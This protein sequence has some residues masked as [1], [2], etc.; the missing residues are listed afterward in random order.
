MGQPGFGKSVTEGNLFE[1]FADAGEGVLLIDVKGDLAEQ[2]VRR[3]KHID[4]VVYVAP[5]AAAEHEH[6][7]S[8]NPLDFDR[9]NRLDFEFYANALFQIFVRVGTVDPAIMVKIKKVMTEAVRL[10]LARR[11]TTLTDVYLA[12]WDADHRAYL[13]GSPS[14]PPQTLDYWVNIFDPMNNREQRLE[15]DNTD[16]RIRD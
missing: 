11:D 8:L 16:T 14:V 3:T 5:H 7:W 13:L 10:A 6:Y 1:G 12:L 15:V 9:G 2:V 4:R